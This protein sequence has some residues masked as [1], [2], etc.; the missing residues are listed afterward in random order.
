MLLMYPIITGA[1][2]DV[3]TTFTFPLL[4]LSLEVSSWTLPPNK[5]RQAWGTH[6]LMNAEAYLH[7]EDFVRVNRH[8]VTYPPI[9]LALVASREPL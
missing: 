7:G 8:W 5:E 6:P 3:Q 1:K 9:G 2:K 4:G